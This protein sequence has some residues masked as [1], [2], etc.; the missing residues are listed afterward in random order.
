M[1]GD[2]RLSNLIYRDRRVVAVL[3]WEMCGIG[4]PL[5]DLGYWLFA[6]E[7]LTLGSGCER[8]PGFPS[9]AETAAEW[10]AATGRSTDAL[11]WYELFAG[12]R[13]AVIMLRMGVLLHEMGLVPDTFPRDNLIT[14]GLARVLARR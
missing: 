13:F 12:F 9:A 10:S 8:L 2:S 6:D 1:W 4:D 14:D 11:P 3:D 5:Q 7:A